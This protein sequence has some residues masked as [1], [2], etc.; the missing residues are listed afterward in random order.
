MSRTKR[1]T[2]LPLLFTLLL[3]SARSALG[4]SCGPTPTVLD[5]FESA[6]V[7]VVTKAV[8]VEKTDKAAPEGHMS[9]GENYVAGVK[10]TTMRVERVYKGGLKAGAEIVFAQGGGANCIWT[11]DEKAVGQQFLFYLAAPKGAGD[12]WYGFGCGRSKGLQSAA[13]DLL[14]LN[15]LDKV[16]GKTRLSGEIRFEDDGST[17]VGGR[18]LRIFGGKKTY[19]VRTGADGVYELYDLPPGKYTVEPEI[20]AGWKVNGF[21]LSYS[22]SVVGAGRDRAH[23]T[24]TKIEVVVPAGRHASLDLYFDIDNAVRGVISDAE[25]GPLNG[26]CLDLVPADGSKGAYLADCT[27]AGGA[28][29]IDE[30]PPGRYVL[31]VNDDGKVSSDEPFETFFYPGAKRREDATV[32]EI[33]RGDFIEG[34]RVVPPKMEETVTVEGVLLYSD[35]RP[36]AGEWVRF[37]TAKAPGGNKARGGEDEEDEEDPADNSEQTDAKGRFSFKILK[38]RAGLL[39]GEMGTYSGEYENCPKL[40]SIIKKMGRDFVDVRTPAVEMRTDESRYGVELKFP[41][42]A[43]KKKV[44]DE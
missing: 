15:K 6:D 31:V 2:T 26:V 4:C 29:E 23:R 42:P 21:Y 8:S 11:F 13:D 36:V 32:F 33:G 37:K 38:A 3:L 9:D 7:V 43:C 19:E 12:P 16:R 35:G 18:L 22:P 17:E 41:F 20:P 44:I 25:G 27:E 24:P 40:E 10:S 1:L 28:F 14:Y 5:A 30:I 39:Y 34:L